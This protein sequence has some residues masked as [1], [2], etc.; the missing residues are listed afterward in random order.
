MLLLRINRVKSQAIQ[1]GKENSEITG[2]LLIKNI[3][4]RYNENEKVRLLQKKKSLYAKNW[5]PKSQ[6]IQR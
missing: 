5:E 3:R 4:R 2:A 1:E 6:A